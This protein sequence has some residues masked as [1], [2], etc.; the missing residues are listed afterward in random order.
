MFK[1]FINFF[2]WRVCRKS[3]SY[4]TPPKFSYPIWEKGIKYIFRSDFELEGEDVF[5]GAILRINSNYSLGVDGNKTAEDICNIFHDANSNI[6][7]VT[8]FTSG[9]REMSIWLT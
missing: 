6:E 3:Y 8:I 5:Q 4:T 1:K 9:R 7:N 2:N